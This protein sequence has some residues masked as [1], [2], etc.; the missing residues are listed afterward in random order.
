MDSRSP[1]G[2]GDKLRGKDGVEAG[3]SR[4]GRHT[5]RPLRLV[6]A[7]RWI[8]GQDIQQPLDKIKPFVRL[9]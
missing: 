4:T 3:D 2:A 8:I 5:D 7:G 1:F 6:G 9:A